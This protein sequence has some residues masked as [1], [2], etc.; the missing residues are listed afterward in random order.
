[1]HVI[2]YLIWAALDIFVVALIVYYVGPL[3]SERISE[4]WYKG[5]LSGISRATEEARKKA[6]ELN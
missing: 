2:D 3:L 6:K 5:K 1:M 4:G